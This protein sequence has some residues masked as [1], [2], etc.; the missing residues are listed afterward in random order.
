MKTWVQT[1]IKCGQRSSTTTCGTC[2]YSE[3]SAEPSSKGQNGIKHDS[4]KPPL[5]IIPL[6]ALELTA[7][8]LGYG[9]QKY[10]RGNFKGGLAHTRL[11]DA[12][13][14]HINQYASG[15]N[16]DPES[17]ESHIGHALASLSMLAYMMKHRPDLD[18]RG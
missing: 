16:L 5:S 9:A 4:N 10:S 3:A 18:D 14:R 1:C 2:T 7:K 8:S 13:L 15:E 17:R 6:E 11:L 12:A